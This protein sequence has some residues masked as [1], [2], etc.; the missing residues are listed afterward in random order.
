MSDER[1]QDITE[2]D[3]G[4]VAVHDGQPDAHD[5]VVVPVLGSD[6]QDTTVF[7]APDAA[8]RVDGPPAPGYDAGTPV[9]GF[10]PPLLGAPE[11]WDAP[12]AAPTKQR[13]GGAGRI[14]A[15]A[16]ASGLLAGAIGGVGAYTIAENRSG[17]SLTS[18]G[19]TIPQTDADLSARP[20]GSI[21]IKLI[22]KQIKLII[23]FY[24]NL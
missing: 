1:P 5:T 7:A 6:A 18:S 11:S 12:P 13:T 10:E 16:V 4:A 9:P 20:D 17:G 24:L 3:T 22:Y 14:V 21:D 19:A 2:P 15:I 23:K 8:A